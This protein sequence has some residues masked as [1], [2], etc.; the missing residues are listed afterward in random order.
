MI[1]W[2]PEIERGI[3]E[4]LGSGGPM[5]PAELGRRVGISEGEAITFL[6]ML[7]REGKVSIRLVGLHAAPATRT[8]PPTGNL[9]EPAAVSGQAAYAGGD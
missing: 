3:L 6:C 5:S 4:C 1:E 8:A 9:G 2:W 7:A